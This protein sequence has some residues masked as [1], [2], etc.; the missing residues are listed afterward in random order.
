MFFLL[1]LNKYFE[2]GEME[3]STSNLIILYLFLVIFELTNVREQN[4]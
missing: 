4:N 2:P 3:W 1:I